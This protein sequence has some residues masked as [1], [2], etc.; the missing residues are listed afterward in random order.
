LQETLRRYQLWLAS[1]PPARQFELRSLPNEQRLATIRRWAEEMQEE[2]ALKLTPEQLQELAKVVLQPLPQLMR[3]LSERTPPD[4]R[5]PNGRDRFDSEFRRRAM[6]Q[7]LDGQGDGPAQEFYDRLLE[8]LP[9]DVAKAFELLSPEKRVDRLQAWIRQATLLRGE[10]SQEELE[11]FFA[12]DLDAA[13]RE[14]LL[15]LPPG[16]MEAA[17]RRLYHS[18]S[19]SP[20]G[21][22][23]RFPRGRERQPPDEGRGDG[24]GPWPGGPP[25]PPGPPDFPPFR[26]E[27]APR[28]GLGPDGPPPR[29]GPEPPSLHSATD[30]APR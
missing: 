16:E 6:L 24:A 29:R 18:Q 26:P 9:D 3:T 28:P 27:G 30:D 22:W 20:W 1:I 12:E 23:G 5:R 2:A 25:G 10:I 13:V 8:A 21:G 17:L 11:R 14:E 19:G 15:L 4:D 7:I